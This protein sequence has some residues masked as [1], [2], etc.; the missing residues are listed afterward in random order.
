MPLRIDVSGL[1]DVQKAALG[2]EDV[3]IAD[4][5]ALVAAVARHRTELRT[6]ATAD[7]DAVWPAAAL[8]H[9]SCVWRDPSAGRSNRTAVSSM[10]ARLTAPTPPS[11]VTTRAW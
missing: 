1:L 10:I 7:P 2:H 11:M 8:M 6:L 5:S 3:S 4:H 9:T